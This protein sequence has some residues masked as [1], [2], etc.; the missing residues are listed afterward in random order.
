MEHH[1]REDQDDPLARRLRRAAAQAVPRV[2][3][4]L[5]RRTLATVHRDTRRRRQWW[6]RV[7]TW[8][9]LLAACLVAALTVTLVFGLVPARGEPSAPVPS[10]AVVSWTPW[11][12]LEDLPLDREW[13][14]LRQDA[15]RAA[16]VV[17]ACLP[18]LR[19][20]AEAERGR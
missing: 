19:P 9:P 2:P 20:A 4:D 15:D 17:V 6:H 12:I 13:R 11:Q 3:D 18:G 14:S 10:L 1:D 8:R 5:V 7:Q 16:Q